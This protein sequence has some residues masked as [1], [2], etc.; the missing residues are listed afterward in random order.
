MEHLIVLSQ[1]CGRFIAKKRD[2]NRITLTEKTVT[3][4]SPLK[5]ETT[6]KQIA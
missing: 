6:V 4:K 2:V 1:T 5:P 3:N